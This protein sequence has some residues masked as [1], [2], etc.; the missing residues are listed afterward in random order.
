MC[1]KETHLPRYRPKKGMSLKDRLLDRIVVNPETGC[2][3]WQG[4]TDE[5]GRGAI[6]INRKRYR[7]HR[8]SAHIYLGMPL[9][10]RLLVCHHCDNPE[11]INPAHLFLGT[12]KDNSQDMVRKGRCRPGHLAGEQIGTAKLTRQQVEE[13]R[14]AIAAGE[15]Q[16]QIA[17]DYGVAR[18]TITWIK[19]GNTWK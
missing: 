15:V 13:I 10:S 8:V 2:W 3:E 7:V 1:R 14:R 18:S 6:G 5:L 17:R 9:D 4:A 12:N 16:A 11:C 19:K